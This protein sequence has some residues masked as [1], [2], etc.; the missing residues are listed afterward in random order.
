MSRFRVLEP[1]ASGNSSS[2][3]LNPESSILN[4]TPYKI[5]NSTSQTLTLV[6]GKLSVGASSARNAIPVAALSEARYLEV[7]G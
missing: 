7:H 2:R 6:V 3:G 5:P 1:A 4:P